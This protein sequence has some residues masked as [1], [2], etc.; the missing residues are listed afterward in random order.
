MNGYVY[1]VLLAMGK[2]VQ[3]HNTV[4]AAVS[5]PY[6]NTY[7]AEIY[8]IHVTSIVLAVDYG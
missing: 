3:S 1:Q 4:I 2:P 5:A 8:V 6:V 7:I